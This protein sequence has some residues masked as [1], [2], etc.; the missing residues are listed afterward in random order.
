MSI[1]RIAKHPVGVL[2]ASA[3]KNDTSSHSLKKLCGYHN[4]QLE[5]VFL[6]RL[7]KDC[8]SIFEMYDVL[9][10]FLISN[11]NLLTLIQ[12]DISLSYL[13]ST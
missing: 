2:I 13:R 7:L 6:T 3:H 10:A 5:R 4:T 11:N 8:F 12:L 1:Q 9:L